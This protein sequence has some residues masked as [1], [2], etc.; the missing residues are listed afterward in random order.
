[1]G[2]WLFKIAYPE[3]DSATCPFGRS[4]NFIITSEN[5]HRFTSH[6]LAA[7]NCPLSNAEKYQLSRKLRKFIRDNRKKTFFD[8]LM[9]GVLKLEEAEIE[10]R[11]EI[12]NEMKLIFS[13][14]YCH[15]FEPRHF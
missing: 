5:A 12:F 3:Q 7:H 11:F 10:G 1:M 2:A 8:T 15:L 13:E 4:C 6:I 14:I 9:F